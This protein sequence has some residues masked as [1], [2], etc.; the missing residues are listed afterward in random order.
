[1]ATWRDVMLP[2]G[3]HP[4]H[5]FSHAPETPSL[6]MAGRS[7]QAERRQE[8]LTGL[9]AEQPQIPPKFFYD[10]QGCALYSAIC[11]LDEYYPVQAEA[12][13]FRRHRADIAA[14]IPRRVQW[15]DLGCSDGGKSW[16]WLEQ[17]GA[18]RYVGVDISEDW[19][20]IALRDAG[21]RFPALDCLGV[22]ADFTRPLDIAPVRNTLRKMP[23]LFF[24]PGSSIGNF[25]PADTLHFLQS[26]QQHL[27]AAGQLLICV[28]GPRDPA[29]IEAAYD[30]A[31]G[32]TAA[33]NRNILRVANR[34][35]DADF[36]PELFVHRAVFNSDESRIEMYLEAI[37]THTVR[38][39]NQ[40]RRFHA[41][42]TILTEC[43]YK[44]TGKAFN[45][46]LEVAGFGNIRHWSG[47]DDSYHVFLAGRRQLS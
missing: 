22:V 15:V 19:L 35:L 5:F 40:R 37:A 4:W 11:Q 26:I 27:G 38:F 30:D 39:G 9:L 24:Y 8:L 28:D 34:E 42:D 23:P 10:A 43:S 14:Q 29:V 25:A 6:V 33:F 3:K 17:V 45:A 7:G 47:D 12:E 2:S 36:E 46:L 21:R 41:G 31:L 18:A 16:P 32:V 20:H 13:I 44:Y 1:M